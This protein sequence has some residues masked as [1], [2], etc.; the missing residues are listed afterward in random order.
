MMAPLPLGPKWLDELSVLCRP[1]SEK[2]LS[3]LYIRGRPFGHKRKR[4]IMSEINGEWSV[5]VDTWLVCSNCGTSY[6]DAADPNNLPDSA[7]CVCGECKPAILDCYTAQMNQAREI[8]RGGLSAKNLLRF[9][10]LTP[11]KQESVIL[12]MI[13]KGTL[14]WTIGKS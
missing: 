8:V 2:P 10:E 14:T 7:E 5:H 13:N 4:R 11:A 6:M 12:G 1:N 3:P 9:D